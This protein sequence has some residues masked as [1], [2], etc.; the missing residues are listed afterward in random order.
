MNILRLPREI[1]EKILLY[2]GGGTEFNRVCSLWYRFSKESY[3][4]KKI[5]PCICR[6]SFENIQ[7][8][9][10]LSHFCVC[11]KN[12]LKQSHFFERFVQLFYVFRYTN[13]KNFVL[14]YLLTF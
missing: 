1:Q 14:F 5:V 7:N 12:D 11:C 10:A 2:V 6:N 13:L 9:K 3:L 4:Q 8:C